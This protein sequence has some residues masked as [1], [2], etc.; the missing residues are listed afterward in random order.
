MPEFLPEKVKTHSVAAEHLCMW[1]RALVAYV[2]ALEEVSS[3][4]VR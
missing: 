1:V 4:C 3:F 2:K